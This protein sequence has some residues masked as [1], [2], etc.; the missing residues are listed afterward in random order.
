[1]RPNY[2][3]SLSHRSD[4]HTHYSDVIKSAMASQSTS[5][6][7]VY[8]TI[9]S[10]VD[11]RKHQSSTS[12]FEGNSPVTGE[13]FAQ[14]ASNAENV[15]IWWRHYAATPTN[16]WYCTWKYDE[17]HHSRYCIWTS[18]M[19]FT[20]TTC[21]EN[22]FAFRQCKNCRT[23][24]YIRGSAKWPPGRHCVSLC[25]HVRQTHSHVKSWMEQQLWGQNIKD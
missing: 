23:R 21:S 10:G 5:L 17:T 15:S 22:T 8:S 18:S 16:Q 9:Y 6:T 25:R 12:L 13:F 4:F 1:M 3:T 20:R 24:A 14:M 7:I 19:I 11:Q 2:C